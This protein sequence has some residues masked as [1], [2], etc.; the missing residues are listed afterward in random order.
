MRATGDNRWFAS[1]GYWQRPSIVI[2]HTNEYNDGVLEEEV[3]RN[4]EL[5]FKIYT[6]DNEETIK[7]SE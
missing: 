5:L 3:K 7:E 2:T 4:K 1:G 6:S